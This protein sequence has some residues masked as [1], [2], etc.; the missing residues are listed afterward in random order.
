M[1]VDETGQDCCATQIDRSGSRRNLHV[2]PDLD[3]PIVTHK[4]DLVR[5]QRA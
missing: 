3:D 1:R 4:D 2:W 5:A